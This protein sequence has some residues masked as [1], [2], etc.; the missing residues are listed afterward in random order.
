MLYPLISINTMSLY[1]C[2]YIEDGWYLQ[3]DVSIHCYSGTWLWFGTL[4]VFMVLLYPIGVPLYLYVVLSRNQHK[5]HRSK[6][7]GTFGF[8]FEQYRK[9]TYYGDVLDTLRKLTLTSIVMFIKPGTSAQVG[10]AMVLSFIFLL[11]N[12]KVRPFYDPCQNQ[13]QTLSLGGICLTLFIGL[14]L[15]G[16]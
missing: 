10:S 15:K 2:R 6:M 5:L 11:Y 3:A 4:G 7:Y 12:V 16:F 8:V 1:N 13:M 9:E 14:L